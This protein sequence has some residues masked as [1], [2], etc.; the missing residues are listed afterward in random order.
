[1]LTGIPLCHF[2]AVKPTDSFSLVSSSHSTVIH[3]SKRSLF[4]S[5]VYF[6]GILY[7]FKKLKEIAIVVR[8]AFQHLQRILP[9]GNF[10]FHWQFGRK[11]GNLEKKKNVQMSLH[12]P[13]K[14]T[15]M[16]NK[17]KKY[18]MYIS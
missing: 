15:K 11:K 13:K 8:D 17:K 3:P 9:S 14:E 5:S 12:F 7:L 16:A 1:M 18:Y 6:H 4:A 10:L 2:T